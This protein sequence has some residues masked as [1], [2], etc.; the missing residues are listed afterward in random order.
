M[1]IDIVPGFWGLTSPAKY[2]PIF[3]AQDKISKIIETRFIRT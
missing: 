2:F 1:D 3:I